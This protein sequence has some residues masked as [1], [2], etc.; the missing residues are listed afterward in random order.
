VRQE[1]ARLG[2]FEFEEHGLS[3]GVRYEIDARVKQGVTTGDDGAHGVEN[4][5]GDLALLRCSRSDAQVVARFDVDDAF[6]ADEQCALAYRMG[7]GA[8]EKQQCGLTLGVDPV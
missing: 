2:E 7:E 5:V 1:Q 3:F 4:G 6:V 8:A